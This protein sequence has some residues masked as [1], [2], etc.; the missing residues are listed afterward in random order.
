MRRLFTATAGFLLIAGGP[1]AAQTVYPIDR[2]EILAGARFDLKVEFLGL[3]E[4]AKVAVTL[5]G[6]DYVKVFGK[7]ASFVEREDGE[8]RSALILRDVSLPKPGTYAV[9]AS[10]G[11]NTHEVAWTVYE[12]GPRKAKNVILFIGDGMSPAHRA[13]ARILAKGISEGKANGKLVI[14]D[15]PHM[16]LVATAGTDSIIT[17]SANSM[18][19]YTTGHK[20]ATSA[21]GVYADRTRDPLDDPKVENITS[22]V[23]R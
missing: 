9:R 10:D 14:D 23:Q 11:V 13:A 6:D 21:M 2:A 15:M 12:T 3:A 20:S 19:A 22:L 16:A 8:P 17:D 5:N 7:A 1:A 4:P 18:S